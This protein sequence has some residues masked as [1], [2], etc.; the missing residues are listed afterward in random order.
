M[1]RV[2]SGRE[3]WLFTVMC[4]ASLPTCMA[5]QSA[6]HSQTEPPQSPLRPFTIDTIYGAPGLNGHLTRGIA[7]TPDSKQFSFFNDVPS[8]RLREGRSELWI[9]EIAS[10]KSRA[11]VSAEKLEAML[12]EDKERPT[13]ATGLGRRAPAEYQWAPSGTALLFRAPTALVWFDLNTQT[14]RTLVSGKAGIADPT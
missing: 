10:G 4:A 14:A 1:R 5:Q 8:S 12:P 13:Q 2:R 9:T 3:F 6:P 11:L 7:W